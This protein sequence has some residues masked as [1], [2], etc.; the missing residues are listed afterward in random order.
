MSQQIDHKL[1]GLKGRIITLL[2]R[3]G[4]NPTQAQLNIGVPVP[5]AAS[6]LDLSAATFKR[7]YSHL[8][9]KPSPRREI[10]RLGNLLSLPRRPP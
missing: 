3:L 4:P 2:G 10:V 1:L 9:E 5:Q 6:Y 8:I 7:R